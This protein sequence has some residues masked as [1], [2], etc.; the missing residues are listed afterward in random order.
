M[1][2]FENPM[3]VL[4]RREAERQHW[5]DFAAQK[6]AEPWRED[7]KITKKPALFAADTW[8][9]FRL[10]DVECGPFRIRPHEELGVF[11]PRRLWLYDESMIDPGYALPLING[12]VRSHWLFNAPAPIT[13]LWE[14]TERDGDWRLW[15]SYT[16]FEIASQRPGLRLAKGHCVVAGLGMGWLLARVAQKKSVTKVTLVEKN[17]DLVN[18]LLPQIRARHLQG[19]EHKLEV[20]IGDANLVV[21]NMTADVALWDIWEGIGAVDA[22]DE[23]RMSEMCF[24]IKKTWF[25]GARIKRE[26]ESGYW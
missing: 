2:F 17:A 15:M 19:V 23:Q 4:R 12:S 5:K 8:E 10:F 22:R 26:K 11:G 25:W 3:H 14:F 7:F 1:F 18:W 24:G 6:P 16:P 21:M 13:R 9:P 20:V